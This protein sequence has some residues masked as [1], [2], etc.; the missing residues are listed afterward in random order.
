MIMFQKKNDDETDYI[1]NAVGGFHMFYIIPRDDPKQAL[2][3]KRFFMSFA[4]YGMWMIIALYCNYDGLFVRCIGMIY[5]IFSLI[6]MT[7]L[8]FY[9]VLRTG[10]NKRLN[11]PSLTMIQMA[12]ATVWIM[13]MAYCL[14]EG[15]GILL[16]LYMVVFTFGTFKLNFRQFCALSV[17]ALMGY[18]LVITFLLINNPESVNLKVELLYLGTLCTVLIWFSFVGSYINDMRKML[19]KT[20]RDLGDANVY[21]KQSEERFRDLSDLL[22]ETVFEADLAG[23]ITFLNRMG[24]QQF[25]FDQDDLDKGLSVFD[26]IDPQDH[27]AVRKYVRKILSGE[28]VGLNEYSARRKD[29]TSFPAMAHTTCIIRDGKPAGFRGLLVDITEKKNLEGQLIRAQKMEAI[30]T[31]AGGIAHEFNNLLMGILGNVSL[32]LMKT[33]E[34]DP[35]YA[36][37][38]KAEEYVERASNLT[39]QLLGFA[40]GGK[41]EV[42]LTNMGEFIKQSSEMFGRTRKEIIIHRRAQD[43]LWTVEIDHSQMEQVFMNLYVNAWQAMPDG[44]ELFISVENVIVDKSD[45]KPYEIIP[46]RY[47]KVTVSDTGIGMDEATKARIFEPFF[48][49]K[50]LGRGSGLGLA[51]VYGIVKHHGG[52]IQVESEAGAGSAFMI[53]LPACEKVLVE[54]KKNDSPKEVR[55]GKGGILLIDDEEMILDVG[56]QMLSHLGYTVMTAQ[57]GKPGIE[58][59]KQNSDKIDLVILDM[60]MPGIGGKE[61]FER[62]YRINS[63]VHILLSSGYSL[64]DHAKEIME[65]GCRGFIQKPFSMGELSKATREIIGEKAR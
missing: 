39:K 58:M 18:S 55:K 8:I 26:A 14:D 21:I 32:I 20:N 51:S 4:S 12:S 9:L 37:L 27:D 63:N 54:E 17:F 52:F 30:G 7:N 23:R 5:W 49:T 46:G 33:D 29:G 57:G 53:F 13:V 50:E 62:L 16:M 41:Y 25:H 19:N 35:S 2:R 56:S 60:I 36:K 45:S 34:D 40:R 11:D 47:V 64:D 28:K 24:F 43:L 65:K 10:L 31:L 61:T 38:K 1:V 15:R 42:R 59:Y 3:I 22:P 48:T 6:I 44:G